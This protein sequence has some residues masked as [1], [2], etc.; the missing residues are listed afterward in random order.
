M[1][2]P[3]SS[4]HAL[5]PAAS[6]CSHFPLAACVPSRSIEKVAFS[7]NGGKDSTV[8]LHLLRAVLE[9]LPGDQAGKMFRS[10]Y[11]VREDDFA[12]V[13]DFVREMDTK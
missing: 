1:R 13:D 12:E 4:L 11:F 10:F 5:R 9:S 6:S 7:F 8:L 2:Q 3:S